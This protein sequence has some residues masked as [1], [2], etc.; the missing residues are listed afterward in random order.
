M[1]T[2]HFLLDL[3]LHLDK[4]LLVV[5]SDYKLWTYLILFIIVF[6]E[7]G[8]VIT[9]FLPGDSLLF[10]AGAISATGSLHIGMLVLVLYIATILGDNINY[11]VGRYIGKSIFDRDHRFIK[12]KYLDKTREF[13]DIHGGK[14]VAIARFV[15]IIR[16]FAPFVAGVGQMPYIRFFSFDLCGGIAWVSIC[17]FAGYFFGNIP[18]VKNNFSV[19]VLAIIFVSVLPIL[20]EYIKMQRGKKS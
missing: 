13:Y 15:P 16:T 6:C 4:H 5:V 3:F 14:T 10:A 12:R 18:V 7:T 20:I 2:L 8:L 11:W 9:P 17:S 19:V 1:Q